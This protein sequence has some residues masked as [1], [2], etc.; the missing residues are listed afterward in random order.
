VPYDC[1]RAAAIGRRCL[2]IEVRSFYAANITPVPEAGIGGWSLED[3]VRAVRQGVSPEGDPYYPAFPYEF[4][5]TLTDT[6]KSHSW[7][8]T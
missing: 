2:G 8:H 7:V 3:L 4:Y 5:A 1:R 6:D